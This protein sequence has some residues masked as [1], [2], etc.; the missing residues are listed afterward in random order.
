VPRGA[1][2]GATPRSGDRVDRQSGSTDPGSNAPTHRRGD[3]PKTGDAVARTSPPRDG[4]GGGTGGG[5]V[6]I[7]PA[8]RGFDPWLGY[9]GF[10]GGYYGA[11]DPWYGWYPTGAS[12]SDDEGSLR[13]KVKPAE[14]SVYVDGDYAGVV[15][16][17][18]GVFQRLHIE[19]GPHRIEIRAPGYETLTFDVQ[20][21]PDHTTT[22]RGE[23]VKEGT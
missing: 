5:G 7:G 21:E 2:E 6:A 18:D 20:I 23:M 13:L 3:Q 15:D 22:Y 16:D 11:Y 19:S 4:G 17:F 10:F 8:Y 12:S 9:G 1:Q 14:A